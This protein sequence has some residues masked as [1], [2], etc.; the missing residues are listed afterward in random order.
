MSV[1]AV[2]WINIYVICFQTEIQMSCKYTKI[3]NTEVFSKLQKHFESC[4]A[5]QNYKSLLKNR[6]PS[7]TC[8]YSSCLLVTAQKL[9]DWHACCVGYSGFRLVWSILNDTFIEGAKYNFV[10][11]ILMDFNNIWNTEIMI[12]CIILF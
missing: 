3:N 7:T 1:I 8:V 12:N 4:N 6:K 5:L 10:Y 11:S 9:S 2:F